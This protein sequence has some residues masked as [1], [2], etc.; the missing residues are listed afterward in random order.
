MISWNSLLWCPR[1]EPSARSVTL[2]GLTHPSP[3]TSTRNGS[4][5]YMRLKW[6]SNTD[7]KHPDLFVSIIWAW[8]ERSYRSLP[9]KTFVHFGQNYGHGHACYLRF[10][11][12]EFLCK[13]SWKR[14]ER[15]WGPSDV[16][17]HAIMQVEFRVAWRKCER[18]IAQST[19]T[20]RR[21]ANNDSEVKLCSFL[22]HYNMRPR[23]IRT[24]SW[25]NFLCL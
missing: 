11:G 13:W 18:A 9:R 17:T 20:A 12:Q 10:V 6:T 8:W 4:K 14:N 1:I 3:P 22:I 2:L 23:K 24:C 19:L 16:G 5:W 15:L 21:T 7:V 25:S